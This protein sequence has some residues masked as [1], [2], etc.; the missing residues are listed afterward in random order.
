MYDWCTAT[1][2]II[3]FVKHFNAIVLSIWYRSLVS[4]DSV[5]LFVG[6]FRVVKLYMAVPEEQLQNWFLC[7]QFKVI[8]EFAVNNM[9]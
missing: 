4:K 5:E 3:G 1:V 2:A 7:P 9:K 8:I 6:P